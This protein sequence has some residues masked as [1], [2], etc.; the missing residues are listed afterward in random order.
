MVISVIIYVVIRVI[1]RE[2][3][4][5][6]ILVII[7]NNNLYSPISANTKTIDQK[8]TKKPIIMFEKKENNNT[9][10]KNKYIYIHLYTYIHTHKYTY[11]PRYIHIYIHKYIYSYIQTY[12]YLYIN[13]LCFKTIIQK[14]FKFTC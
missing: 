4:R 11:L 9:G 5:V 3:I 6:V 13:A 8:C 2:V 10:K 1:F 12:V 7:I 14:H